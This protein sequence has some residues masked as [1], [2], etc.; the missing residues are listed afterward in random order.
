[1]VSALLGLPV[2]RI[3]DLL[4]EGVLPRRSRGKYDP[5]A[6]AAAWVK[7]LAN[8]L[9]R[10]ADHLA[11]EAASKELAA[12]KRLRTQQLTALEFE[13]LIGALVATCLAEF[14]DMPARI[15]G[16]TDQRQEITTVV[17]KLAGE[18]AARVAPMMSIAGGSDRRKAR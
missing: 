5:A 15:G 3:N 13:R 6:A 11:I 12:F 2:R 7:Y 14:S 18:F 17:A 8:D 10:P 4:G 16:T 9:E 1:M